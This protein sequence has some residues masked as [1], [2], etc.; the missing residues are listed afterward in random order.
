MTTAKPTPKTLAEGFAI[1]LD[2]V[3]PPGISEARQEIERA[4]YAGVW[5]A[6]GMC[7]QKDDDWNL[8]QLDKL[9]VECQTHIEKL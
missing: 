7:M 8:S 3:L 4:F 9:S 1:Y 5:I 2:D 6:L